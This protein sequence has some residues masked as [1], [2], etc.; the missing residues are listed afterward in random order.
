[1]VI[2][3]VSVEQSVSPLTIDELAGFFRDTSE[4]VTF[5]GGATEL[6]VG[7]PLDPVDTVV[8]TGKLDRITEYVPADLTIHVEAGVRVGTLLDVLGERRQLLPLDPWTGPEAT[9][10]GVVATNAQ[11]ALR[12]VGTIRDWIIGMKVVHSDGR[13]SKTGGRVVKNVSGYDLAKLYTGSIGSLGAIAEV[14]FKLRAAWEA[15]A[16]A[17][18][19]VADMEDAVRIIRDIRSGP[20]QPIAFVWTGPA[21]TIGVRFGEH[22]DAVRW[23]LGALPGGDWHHLEG[24]DERAFWDGVAGDFRA[25]PEPVVRVV[26]R[27]SD[28]A[29]VIRD[30]TTSSWIAHAG[31]GTVMMSVG[32]SGFTDRLRALRSR[33]P[34]VI[35]RAAVDDRRTGG[36]FGVSG[37]AYDLMKGMKRA[38]DPG[39]RLNPGRHVDGE[40]PWD[41]EGA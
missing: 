22:P 4:R 38:M 8:R 7:N 2:D 30:F 41:G 31:L 37:P 26:A 33:F 25:M 14:S 11:G 1:M 13:V 35:E 12:T 10:G 28:V 27:P 34:C 40:R 24:D 15:T 6:H 39:G 19:P 18:L 29:G 20:V 17:C 21:H 32:A 16:T 3:S 23:Q 36:T 9:I 5:V